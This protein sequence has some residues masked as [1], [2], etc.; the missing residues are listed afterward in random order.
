M[1]ALWLIKRGTWEVRETPMPLPKEGEVR[2]AVRA[3]G[4]NFAELM[5]SNG[6]YPD[7]PKLPAILGYEVAGEIDAVGVGIDASRIGER[8]VALTHFGGHAQ[9]CCV[10][11]SVALAVPAG[12]SFETAAA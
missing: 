6:L 11:S 12:M 7:A 1:K 2:I 10:P 9:S 5:A 8:V 3:F 4:L